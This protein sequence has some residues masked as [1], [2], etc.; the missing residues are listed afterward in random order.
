MVWRARELAICLGHEDVI[1]NFDKVR[2]HYGINRIAQVGALAALHDQPYL[3]A[4]NAKVAAGRA[5]IAA[6]ASRQD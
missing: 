3:E 2:N 1:A 6:I 5:R 4:T